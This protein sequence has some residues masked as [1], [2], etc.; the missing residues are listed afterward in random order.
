MKSCFIYLTCSILLLICCIEKKSASL[1]ETT[2][3]ARDA[4]KP[5]FFIGRIAEHGDHSLL[6]PLKMKLQITSSFVKGSYSR[7][8]SGTEVDLVGSVN[9][10][11]E[12]VMIEL[13]N[14]KTTGTFMGILENGG[15]RLLKL[16]G[17][18]TGVNGRNPYQFSVAEVR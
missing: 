15:N 9:R 2:G 16:S 5:R 13:A 1:I 6:R 4:S 8:N 3:R 10:E 11:N 14:G 17:V 12:L 7:A 18:W